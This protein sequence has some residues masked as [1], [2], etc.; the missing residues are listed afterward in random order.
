MR[1]L[2]FLTLLLLCTSFSVVSDADTGMLRWCGK[3]MEADDKGYLLIA[4]NEILN[5]SEQCSLEKYNEKMKYIGGIHITL[6]FTKNRS[7]LSNWRKFSNHI[8]EVRGKLRD[9][10]IT[11]TRFV[12]DMGN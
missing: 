7:A 11:N 3:Y 6:D 9:N 8:I 1:K 12:R 5:G 10:K 2:C 4:K